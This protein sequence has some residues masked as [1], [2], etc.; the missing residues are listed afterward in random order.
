MAEQAKL[1]LGPD[2]MAAVCAFR[3][4]LGRRT[5]ATG[6][7]SA[8]LV[9]IWPQLCES[10]QRL[11]RRDLGEAVAMDDA[12]RAKGADYKPLGDNCDRAEWMR[13]WAVIEEPE[14]ANG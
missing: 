7:V 12:A 11:I 5:Y 14:S 9:R 1:D 2:D 3:Y 10:A 4:A 8:W 13:L 6:E